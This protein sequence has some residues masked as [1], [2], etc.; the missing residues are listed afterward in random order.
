MK[1][2]SKSGQQPRCASR[3][4]TPDL[5]ESRVLFSGAPNVII[6]Q[7]DDLGYGDIRPY[8]Q[9]T[10]QTPYLEQLAS[11]GM[12][13]TNYYAGSSL[14]SPSRASLLTGLHT[15]HTN[16]QWLGEPL[17]SDDYTVAQM[18]DRAGYDTAMIGKWHVANVNDP[19]TLP[20]GRGFDYAFGFQAGAHQHD[21]WSP[22]I[23][24][25]DVAELVPGN[26]AGETGTYIPELLTSDAVQYIENRTGS[27]SPFFLLFNINTPHSTIRNGIVSIDVPTDAPYTDEAWPQVEKNF[28]ASVTQTDDYVRRI[29]EAVDNAGL[30]TDTLILFTSDNGPHIEAGHDPTFFNS[31]GGLRGKKF[32]LWEGGI[33]VPMIARWTGTIA[34]DVET[35]EISAAWDIL[36]T[37]GELANSVVPSRLDGTSLVPTLL[38]TGPEASDRFVYFQQTRNSATY[39]AARW[40]D[41]K[42]VEELSGTRRLFDLSTNPQETVEVSAAYPDVVQSMVTMMENARAGGFFTNA[43]PVANSASESVAFEESVDRTL[44]ASD[45]DADP[46]L[47]SIVSGPSNGMLSDFN[48]VTGAYTYTPSPGFSGTDSLTFNVFD[49]RKTSEN[50]TVSFTVAPPPAIDPPVGTVTGVDDD[51]ILETGV[52]G[53]VP[54]LSNDVSSQSVPLRVAS[55]TQPT[56]G[57]VALDDAGTP[58]DPGDDQLTYRSNPFYTGDDA[59]TYTVTDDGGAVSTATVRVSVRN[60]LEVLVKGPAVGVPGQPLDYILSLVSQPVAGEPVD[61][62]WLIDFD[63]DGQTDQALSGPS[64]T[65]LTHTYTDVRQNTLRVIATDD[66]NGRGALSTLPVEIQTYNLQADPTDPGKRAVFVGGTGG[67]DTTNVTVDTTQTRATVI[68]NGIKS[69]PVVFDGGIVQFGFTGNDTLRVSTFSGRTSL[70]GGDGN[71]TLFGAGSN[72]LLDGGA[73]NDLLNGGR[74]ADVHIGGPGID[75][76]TYT[77][78]QD[79]LTITLDD[80]PNDGS[81]FDGPEGAR[82]D[83]RSDVE[84]IIGGAANDFISGSILAN[85]LRGNAGND[86]LIGG[87]GVDQLFGGAGNDLLDARDGSPG[88]LLN[89]E[90]G[91]DIGLFDV[92]DKRVSIP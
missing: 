20:T 33:R 76:A 49:T 8:G 7:T 83:V 60:T 42:L 57:T 61:L 10:I 65:M 58:L 48:P 73:G 72:D 47:F 29:V 81:A 80:L 54:V 66:V 19:S 43:A 36:P 17:G 28:A 51:V 56:F 55:F 75:T 35:D 74:G 32:S 41:W 69:P 5:L 24:R 18:L 90:A 1:R 40:N 30:G 70:F 71:D 25:N 92:G 39:Y 9:T 14:C 4:F 86:T 91:T 22:K 13:F 27:E 64:G 84:I 87:A 46:L 82:D 37:L 38:G 3:C 79:A 15:G 44:G 67:N 31:S 16:V 52:I 88:D 6:I 26:Q 45:D 12:R 23:F 50:T 11:E 2:G 62:T 89:G 77:G 34:P 63:G 59:F 53:F 21:V 68:V 78:R 85:T